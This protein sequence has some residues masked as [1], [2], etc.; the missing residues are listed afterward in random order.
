MEV[1]VGCVVGEVMVLYDVLGV[2]VRNRMI[3][4]LWFSF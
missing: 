4:F 1:V 3:F 2:L